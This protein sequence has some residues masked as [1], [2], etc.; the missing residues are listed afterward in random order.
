[1]AKPFPP[2]PKSLIPA[3]QLFAFRRNPIA[4][5][6]N[7]ARDFGDI[8][9]FQAGSQHYF[10]INHPEYIKNI[11]VTD[12]AHFKKGRGLERAKRMLGNGLL[13]SEGAFHRR[14]RRL[15]QPAFHR[16]R[17]ARYAGIMVE[18]ADRLQRERWHDGQT[19]D[20]AKEMMH[21]TLAIVGKTLFD[22]ETEAEAEQVR[23]AVSESMEP[24]NRFMLPF[25][26]ILDR[27]PL[28]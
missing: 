27:L 24:F 21:L 4:F 17:I 2:G 9:H 3:G 20:V 8:A 10:L 19:L 14:Q 6:T 25:S 7:A 11:L 18:Y 5:L 28:P 23:E 22:T 26:A 15:A 12:H 1:M 16:D 13:T